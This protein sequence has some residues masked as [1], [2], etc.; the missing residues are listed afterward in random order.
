VS[1]EGITMRRSSRGEGFWGLR[2]IFSESYASYTHALALA[3]DRYSSPSTKTAFFRHGATTTLVDYIG[4]PDGVPLLFRRPAR[5]VRPRGA[6]CAA[7]RC[8][9]DRRKASE[10]ARWR[11]Y[12]LSTEGERPPCGK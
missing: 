12:T 6:F 3:L 5:G 4:V 8:R 2:F 9:A 1:K 11:E 7:R 10:H